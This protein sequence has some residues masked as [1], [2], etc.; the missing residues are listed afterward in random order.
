MG[1]DDESTHFA[2]A[3]SN[4]SAIDT[5]N[6]VTAPDVRT[7]V[8]VFFFA[9]KKKRK[10]MMMRRVLR[11]ADAASFKR[12]EKSRAVEPESQQVWMAGAK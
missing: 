1:R 6:H 10:M 2:D 11:A 12:K 5:G 8:R 7:K 4:Q 9:E 3:H